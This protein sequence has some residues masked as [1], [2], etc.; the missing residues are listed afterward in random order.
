MHA[1][2]GERR[3]REDATRLLTEDELLAVSGGMGWDV[4]PAV[5]YGAVGSPVIHVVSPGAI[6]IV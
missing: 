1:F 2:E 5:Q 4:I 3:C 6:H